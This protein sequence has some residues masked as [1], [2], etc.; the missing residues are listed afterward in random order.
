MLERSICTMLLLLSLSAEQVAFLLV[1]F[2][3]NFSMSFDLVNLPCL[4]G[5]ELHR[6]SSV[7]VSPVKDMDS[8]NKAVSPKGRHSFDKLLATI[9]AVS[10]AEDAAKVVKLLRNLDDIYRINLRSQHSDFLPNRNKY[11]FPTTIPL[12]SYW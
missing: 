7:S 1:L 12:C 5:I 10:L 8:T 2:E 3:P 11:E 4:F 9:K 6:L